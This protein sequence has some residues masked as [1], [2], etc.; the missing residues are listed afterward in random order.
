MRLYKMAL[1]DA[2]TEEFIGAAGGVCSVTLAGSA[3]K[4]NLY[5]KDGSALANPVAI[6]NGMIEF[7]V[8][9]NVTSVDI[10][11]MAPGGQFV[12]RKGVAGS[13]PNDINIDTSQ[14]QQVAVIPFHVADQAGDNT[15]TDSGFDEPANA[16]FTSLGTV[17]EVA[18]IDA[19]E[20][21]DAGTDGSD[22]G[23]P[24]GFVAAASLANAGLVALSGALLA[25]TGT[26]TAHI[27]TGKSITWTLSA[28]ADTA[29]GFVHLP[30]VLT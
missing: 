11:V 24:N 7:A 20:T 17:I 12:V 30:Y 18:A 8:G 22:S 6:V 5:N 21:V 26:P 14:K 4:A 1:R 23:D 9:D 19:T 2:I 13:G 3:Q 28:G 16:V 10:Y 27:S 29:E 25:N 15:E